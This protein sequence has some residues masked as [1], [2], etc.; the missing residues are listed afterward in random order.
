MRRPIARVALLFAAAALAARAGGVELAQPSAEAGAPTPPQRQLPALELDKETLFQFLLGELA[1]Q[2]G[3]LS[4]AARSF[5]EL[6]RRTRDARIARRAVE[7]ANAARNTALALEAA[8][9]WQQAEPDSPQALRALALL[10]LREGLLEEAEPHLARVL[11]ENPFATANA[12][13]Q[14]G[15]LLVQNADR[16]QALALLERL[17]ARHPKLPEAHFAVAQAAAAARRDEVALRALARASELRP[18]WMAAALLEAQLLERRAPARAAERLAAFL[19]R[20]PAAREARLQYAR[21]L[22]ADGRRAEAQRELETL[23]AIH[24]DD[25]EA[26][27]AAGVLA[28]QARLYDFAESCF[29]RLLMAGPREAARARFALGQLAEERRDWG[30]ALEWYGSI[31]GG[32]QAFSARLRT[33]S[34]LARQG[35]VEEGRALL[36]AIEA[37]ENERIT[38]L[39]AEAQ[40]LREAARH[41]EAFDLLDEALRKQPEQPELLYDQALTAEKLDRLD[42]LERN[43]RKLIQ[44]RPDHAHAYNALGYT[45]ADRNLRLEEARALIERALELAPDDSFIIDSMG[46]VLYRMGNLQGA[47]EWLWRAWRGR[48]DAEIGAHLGEVLWMLG[49]RDEAERIWREVEEHSPDN[50]TL[51]KTVERLRR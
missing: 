5:V 21:L 45:L 42:V 30:R 12:F 23:L 40:L 19:E 26:V 10:L 4:L 2:R 49:E 8:R 44:I 43:L 34:V 31:D 27:Y 6:A 25:R 7:L 35:K 38:L 17:A 47:R 37:A 29:Q 39:L 16:A 51:R 33:A 50:E 9:V 36:R 15:Q 14:L 32:E 28:M 48:R 3:E 41:R 1:A 46:W 18:D 24:R 20:Q 22:V 13:L 11:E